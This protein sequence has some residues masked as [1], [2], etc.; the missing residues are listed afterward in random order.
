[1][2]SH[3]PS[4]FS[5]ILAL[6][7]PPCLRADDDHN[8]YDSGRRRGKRTITCNQYEGKIYLRP[9][10]PVATR[11][12]SQMIENRGGVGEK[13]EG[14]GYRNDDRERG[15]VDSARPDEGVVEH[16]GS[17]NKGDALGLIGET[18]E[19]VEPV[20]GEEEGI[21]K[22]ILSTQRTK[23][24]TFS[25]EMHQAIEAL[26]REEENVAEAITDSEEDG[27]DSSGPALEIDE[28]TDDSSPSTADDTD[29]KEKKQKDT[30]LHLA[31]KITLQHYPQLMS[32]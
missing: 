28:G 31:G 19:A 23:Q 2:P 24:R 30:F 3:T 11:R 10:M 25:M 26:H 9:I 12:K 14:E 7:L 29:T 4:L 22:D 27:S 5:T 8:I 17:E 13:K 6:L 18:I 21:G 15:R 32:L 20:G 1:M 16:E